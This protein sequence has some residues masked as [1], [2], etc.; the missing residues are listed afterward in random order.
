MV[1]EFLLNQGSCL[2]P[3]TC[4]ASVPRSIMTLYDFIS[5]QSGQNRKKRQAS[6]PVP[7]SPDDVIVIDP[8]RNVNGELLVSFVVDGEGGQS[9]PVSG[10]VLV[11][12]LQMDGPNLATALSNAVCD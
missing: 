1:N 5:D 12:L 7:V 2:S 10:T 8:L 3:S 9:T 6:S 4:M 11:N